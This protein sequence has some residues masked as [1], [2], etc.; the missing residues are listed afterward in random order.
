VPIEDADGWV[1]ELVIPKIAT[2]SDEEIP[3]PIVQFSTDVVPVPGVA[4]V[5][6][7]TSVME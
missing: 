7:C 6:V 2:T 3:A 1:P 5:P 4:H